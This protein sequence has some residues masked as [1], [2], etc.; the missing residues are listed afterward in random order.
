MLALRRGLPTYDFTEP[1]VNL[2]P[3]QHV[4]GTLACFEVRRS[5]SK[6]S[7][8]DDKALLLEVVIGLLACGVKITDLC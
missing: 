7:R 2:R 1:E 8:G 6:T 5:Q 4:R 3:I